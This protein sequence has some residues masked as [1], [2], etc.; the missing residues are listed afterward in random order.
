[1]TKNTN[2]LVVKDINEDSKKIQKAKSLNI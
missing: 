1:L 2:I